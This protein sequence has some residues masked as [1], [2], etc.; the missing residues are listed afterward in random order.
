[1]SNGQTRI[2][3]LAPHGLL[4][5]GGTKSYVVSKDTHR[6]VGCVESIYAVSSYRDPIVNAWA[7]S[8]Y[9]VHMP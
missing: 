7:E 6:K 1:M 5:G 8:Q 4:T 9:N 2:S 3:H